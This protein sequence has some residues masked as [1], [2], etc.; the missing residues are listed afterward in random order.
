MMNDE[1]GRSRGRSLQSEFSRCGAE[2]QREK[3]DEEFGHTI[4]CWEA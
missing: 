3:N 2:T 4:E 1:L